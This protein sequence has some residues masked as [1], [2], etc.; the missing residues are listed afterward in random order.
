MC[1]LTCTVQTKKHRHH[2]TVLSTPGLIQSQ[3]MPLVISQTKVE[4][5][6]ILIALDNKSGLGNFVIVEVHS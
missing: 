4:I 5:P 2:L 6:D 3:P 1:T